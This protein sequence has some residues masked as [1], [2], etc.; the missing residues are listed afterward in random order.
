MRLGL[1]PARCERL[2]DSFDRLAALYS[3]RL[4]SFNVSDNRAKL[5]REGSK[6][7]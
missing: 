5:L 3:R 4:G 2:I 1:E 7:S 6:L